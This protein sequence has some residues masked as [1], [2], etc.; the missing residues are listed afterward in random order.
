ME[1]PSPLP[2]IWLIVQIFG[3]IIALEGITEFLT[4]RQYESA[5]RTMVTLVL[6]HDPAKPSLPDDWEDWYYA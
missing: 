6:G 2:N 3:C 1:R 4:E 5:V